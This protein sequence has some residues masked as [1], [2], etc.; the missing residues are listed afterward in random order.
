MSDQKPSRDVSAQASR[1]FFNHQRSRKP[2]TPQRADFRE[3]FAERLRVAPVSLSDKTERPKT[4]PQKQRPPF[5]SL[6]LSCPSIS[7]S[8]LKQAGHVAHQFKYRPQHNDGHGGYRAPGLLDH[9]DGERY[10]LG[11]EAEEA[12]P[13]ER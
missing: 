9:S 6:S 5:V 3:Q 4:R 10:S 7:S 2:A 12:G 1:C 13:Q 8:P 11:Q